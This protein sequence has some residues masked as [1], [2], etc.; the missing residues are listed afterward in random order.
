MC[1]AGDSVVVGAAVVFGGDGGTGVD[2]TGVDGTDVGGTDVGGTGV[3]DKV[4]DHSD[5]VSEDVE[6]R[7]SDGVAEKVRDHSD[8]VGDGRLTRNPFSDELEPV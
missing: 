6:V 8:R 2:G 5:R 4:R 3:T 7:G 1:F